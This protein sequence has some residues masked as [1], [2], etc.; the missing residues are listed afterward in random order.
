[1]EI[2]NIFCILAKTGAGK[3]FYYNKIIK[4]EQFM[5]KNN[6]SALVYGTTRKPRKGESEGID[7]YFYSRE[8]YK[9]IPYDDLIE[10]RT[11]YTVNDGKIS[12][13]TK[14]EFFDNKKN[15]ICIT[16]PYQY[17]SYKNWCLKENILQDKVNYNLY[18][19]Y[20]DTDLK[21]RISRIT[22]RASTDNDIY[23]MCRRC[24]EEKSEFENVSKH[25]AEIENPKYCNN[26]IYICNNSEDNRI[27]DENLDD[28]KSFI[29]GIINY[30]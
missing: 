7:Y 19:I 26:S 15:V 29:E 12:Y 14:K 18:L 25:V 22:N 10:Q 24:L 16:S 23:E 27:I 5:G 28:I 11:Y 8:E 2:R 20:I 3:S 21:I 9:K 30:S 17:E 1:M 13:F 6:I 4:D